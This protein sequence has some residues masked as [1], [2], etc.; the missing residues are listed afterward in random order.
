[1]LALLLLLTIKIFLIII[2]WIYYNNLFCIIITCLY[3]NLLWK[4]VE[5]WQ[6]L[7]IAIQCN[8]SLL[9]SY[10]L[11]FIRGVNRCGVRSLG[12]QGNLMDNFEFILSSRICAQKYV[13]ERN[14]I[15]HLG[16]CTSPS[17]K[18]VTLNDGRCLIL[19]YPGRVSIDFIFNYSRTSPIIHF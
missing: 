11:Q 14:Q 8:T 13:N 16:K 9:T 15:I 17:S 10:R 4:H 5:N 7:L 6:E 12:C 2:V 19:N 1:M 3:Y 18:L